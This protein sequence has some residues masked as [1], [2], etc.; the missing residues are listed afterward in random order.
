[1]TIFLMV[2][3]LIADYICTNIHE[4]IFEEHATQKAVRSSRKKQLKLG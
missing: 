4:S 3:P 2:A 1:M